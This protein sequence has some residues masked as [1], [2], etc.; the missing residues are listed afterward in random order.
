M[1]I[2]LGGGG[3]GTESYFKWVQGNV[4]PDNYPSLLIRFIMTVDGK[5]KTSLVNFLLCLF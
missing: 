5:Y 3:G 4:S 2:V 1:N